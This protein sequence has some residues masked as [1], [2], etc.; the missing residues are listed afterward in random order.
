MLVNGEEYVPE[1]KGAFYPEFIT[2]NEMLGRGYR[3]DSSKTN[4][5]GITNSLYLQYSCI[6]GQAVKREG[7]KF[8]QP[9]WDKQRV[10]NI[11]TEYYLEDKIPSFGICVRCDAKTRTIYQG[12]IE[13]KEQ[14]DLILRL[15]D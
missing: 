14:L 13:T 4:D 10:I 1:P 9:L 5:E 15:A 12:T 8:E 6:E 7:K 11:N 2:P 3:L